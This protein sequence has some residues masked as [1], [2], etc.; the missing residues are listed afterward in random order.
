MDC[1]SLSHNCFQCNTPQLLIQHTKI[2]DISTE[3]TQFNQIFLSTKFCKMGLW[4][5][6]WH[7]FAKKLGWVREIFK[8]SK[9]IQSQRADLIPASCLQ[10]YYTLI[11]TQVKVKF[12][13][14][15]NSPDFDHVFM[16]AYTMLTKQQFS[17]HA[18]SP[19]LLPITSL[20]I[21]LNK[22]CQHSSHVF[23]FTRCL[24]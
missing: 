4:Q 21:E 2:Q 20:C 16:T 18:T 22:I 19:E 8:P 6:L 13:Q 10:V 23:D 12:Y 3:R 11:R 7:Y 1:C 24:G 17:N 15:L 9:S 14:A 5:L